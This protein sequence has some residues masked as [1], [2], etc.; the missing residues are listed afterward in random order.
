MDAEYIVFMDGL[1]G[2]KFMPKM[3]ADDLRYV[4]QN[5]QED[6]SQHWMYY[7]YTKHD[8]N[9]PLHGTRYDTYKYCKSV[10][11]S[12]VEKP[13]MGNMDYALT[14]RSSNAWFFTD[15]IFENCD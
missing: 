14:H 2:M 4:I 15:D 9:V 12:N 8:M 1:S 13:R 10:A 3:G 6:G 7:I 5:I 11:G